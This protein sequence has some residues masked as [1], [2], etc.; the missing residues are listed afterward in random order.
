MELIL[1]HM[2]LCHCAVRAKHFARAR[3]T[4]RTP[5]ELYMLQHAKHAKHA[6]YAR[7]LDH[8]EL[9]EAKELQISPS[10]NSICKFQRADHAIRT[11]HS[12]GLSSETTFCLGR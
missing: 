3:L 1:V 9:R 6:S 10:S 4:D 7:H 5:A 11:R 8:V 12:L 2:T